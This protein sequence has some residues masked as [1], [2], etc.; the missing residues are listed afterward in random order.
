LKPALSKLMHVMPL[1]KK[2]Q[3]KAKVLTA[4]GQIAINTGFNCK[5]DFPKNV[6]AF[7]NAFKVFNLDIVPSLGLQCS[8]DFDYCSRIVV[9]SI[10]PLIVLF[11][12]LS[13]Y[14]KHVNLEVSKNNEVLAHEKAIYF[15]P[16]ELQALF[17]NKLEKYRKFFKHYDKNASGELDQEEV[18][19]MFTEMDLDATKKEINDYVSAF[20]AAMDHDGSGNIDFSEFLRGMRVAVEQ[21]D[22][23][24]FASLAAKIDAKATQSRGQLV[25]YLILL[26]TFLVLVSTST[27]IFHYFDCDYFPLPQGGKRAFLFVDYSIGLMIR[28]LL[29]TFLL[30]SIAVIS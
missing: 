20:Y 29:P 3:V 4:F 22:N 5:V 1:F 10:C 23:C 25:F 2:A 6:I 11:V 7:M 26:L 21:P 12:L 28:S 16:E 17:G 15:A 13:L 18:T 24:E 9:V 30:I 14:L 19:S 27:T 8:L